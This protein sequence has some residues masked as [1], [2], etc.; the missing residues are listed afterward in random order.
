MGLI[1]TI[2]NTDFSSSGTPIDQILPIDNNPVLILDSLNYSASTE[3]WT[4]VHT[5][6]VATVPPGA[7]APTK[8]AFKG[9]ELPLF[10]S[11]QPRSLMVE[12][13]NPEITKFT[14]NYVVYNAVQSASVRYIF[15]LIKDSVRFLGTISYQESFS[16]TGP[17]IFSTDSS[18]QDLPTP[19]LAT[20][21]RAII[22]LAVDRDANTCAVYL[23]GAI[24]IS[25]SGFVVKPLEGNLFFGR[26]NALAAPM[27]GYLAN[28]SI[29]EGVFDASKALVYYNVMSGLYPA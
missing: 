4:D 17:K 19:Q 28:F 18:W 29:Y 23:N 9:N 13:N 5:S 16:T 20:G 25:L 2:P 22:S 21:E 7:V 6:K 3:Q 11:D 10:G 1:F 12:L 15:D 8:V 27:A 14:F 26:S 24:L